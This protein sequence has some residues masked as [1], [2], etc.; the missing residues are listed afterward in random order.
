MSS[1][2]GA[3]PK[4]AGSETLTVGSIY[5]RLIWDVSTDTLHMWV[6]YVHCT[7]SGFVFNGNLS[8]TYS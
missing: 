2:A 1:G 7:E 4:Q 5:I 3:G 8:R 6:V